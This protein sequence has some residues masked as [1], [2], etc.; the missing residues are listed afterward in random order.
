MSFALLQE[1]PIT[2]PEAVRTSFRLLE[3]PAPWIVALILVP[4]ILWALTRPA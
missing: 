4:S 2:D 3:M 1:N